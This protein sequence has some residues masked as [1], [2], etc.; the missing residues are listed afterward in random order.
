MIDVIESL[1]KGDSE[2]PRAFAAALP[3]W[4]AFYNRHYGTDQGALQQAIDA[5][6]IPF[7]REM[8]TKSGLT[9]PFAKSIMV[10]TAIGALYDD[11]FEDEAFTRLVLD[12]FA[13]STS[14]SNEVKS[15]TWDI[16]RLYQLD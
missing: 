16:A 6:Q 3:F 9:R 4:R 15:S 13:N 2:Y 11:G 8:Q 1:M 12:C 10:L 5:A 7:E 14:L